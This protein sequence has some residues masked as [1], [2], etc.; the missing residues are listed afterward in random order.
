MSFD[1]KQRVH[2]APDVLM[3]YQKRWIADHSQVKVCE[4]SRRVG[5]SWATAAEAVL[6]AGAEKGQD[7]WYISYSEDNA[8]EFILDAADWSRHLSHAASAIDEALFADTDENGETKQI[9]SYVITYASGYRITALSSRPRNLRSRQGYVVAD[10]AAFVDDLPALKKAAMAFLMWGGRV[11]IISTHNGVDNAFNEL[12]Q[13]IREGKSPYSLHRI[14][15][16]DALRDGLYQRICLKTGET[17]SAEAEAKWRADLIKFYGAGWEEELFCV[18]RNSGGVYVSRALLEARAIDVPVLRLAVDDD[19]VHK[20]DAYRHSFIAEWLDTHVVPLLRALPDAPHAFG[21]DFARS[22]LTVMVPL[23]LEQTM[24]RRPP[25]MLELR[26]VPF[27]EQEQ[28]LFFILDRLP[29]FF[30]A[31]LDSRGNGQSIGEHAMQKYGETRVEQVMLSERWY[32]ENCPPF[33]AAIEDATMNVPRDRDVILDFAG[34][35]EVKAVPKFIEKERIGSDKQKRHWDAAVALVLA[36][37]ASRREVGPI[38]FEA[39]S[40]QQD[41]RDIARAFGRT[42]LRGFHG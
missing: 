23:T 30:S 38:E 42:D 31:C 27:T 35:Q 7:V 2:R 1:G 11:A 13:E 28:I 25:F 9:K 4:K 22:G 8:L 18:P 37:A 6:V 20:T 39:V 5:I 36:H 14:T 41:T 24:N 29:R 10:E 12:I 26:N 16:D 34:L 3:D 32:S 15:L 33:R 21:Q 19:F 17:W 40:R